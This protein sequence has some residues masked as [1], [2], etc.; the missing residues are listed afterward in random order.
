MPSPVTVNEIYGN[1]V[2]EVLGACVSRTPPNWSKIKKTVEFAAT[3]LDRDML[4][5]SHFARQLGE[6]LIRVDDELKKQNVRSDMEHFGKVDRLPIMNAIN[7]S[8]YC[9]YIKYC[10]R[11][12]DALQF[13]R[14]D[15]I[16]P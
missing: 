7:M 14:E 5:I 1:A 6:S 16:I 15:G 10:G 13:L 4:I 9:D 3:S 2:N 12:Q 11:V 8:A